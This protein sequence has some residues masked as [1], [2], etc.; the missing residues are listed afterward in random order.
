MKSQ[1][2]KVGLTA[3]AA[4]LALLALWQTGALG[5]KSGVPADKP[6]PLVSVALAASSDLPIKLAA[7]GHLI[8]LNQVDI[9]PQANGIVR[10][11]H[12]REGE[13]VKAGQLLFT[14]DSSDADSQLAHA[15]AQ[16][17]QVKAQ[18]DD[19]ERDLA[20]SRRLASSRFISSSAVD[21]S[22]SKLESLKA[23]HRAA[24]ADIQNARTLLG[25][26][27]LGAPIAGLAGAL[28]VHPG[29]LAQ[30]GAT[31]AP[32]VTL[33]QLDPI[34]VEFTLPESNLADVLAARGSNTVQISLESA[35]GKPKPGRLVFINNTVNTDTATITMKAEFPNQAKTLWPGA[36]VRLVIGAGTHPGSIVLPPQAVLEGPAGRFV[37]V[38]GA[39]NTVTAAPVK[40]LRIQ[41]QLAVVEGLKGGERVVTEGGQNL[42]PGARVQVA[43]TA[44]EQHSAT[45]ARAPQ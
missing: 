25:R 19:G 12:F 41:D 27:R 39:D 3:G 40:L 16:A 2:M 23:Q 38:L 1:R 29:S 6:P 45:A 42:K 34:G 5:K 17:E 20:R 11:V 7:Q 44:V 18:V 37:Y 26:T 14:L 13:E 8:A 9:R 30:L 33:V 21:T 43:A 15:S 36:F 22:L 24:L 28:N 31:N 4:L 10:Q 32:L 35:D